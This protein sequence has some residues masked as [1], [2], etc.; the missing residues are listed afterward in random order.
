MDKDEIFNKA[1]NKLIPQ[2][3]WDSIAGY[4]AFEDYAKN[5]YYIEKVMDI[6][7]VRILYY[8]LQE[9]IIMNEFF[10][11]MGV[12]LM[13][14]IL[15]NSSS[16]DEKLDQINQQRIKSLTELYDRMGLK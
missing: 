2:N 10:N 16:S 1:R 4:P 12:E 7:E 13:N 5:K 15:D 3:L 6:K 14:E 11:K 8:A 9:S